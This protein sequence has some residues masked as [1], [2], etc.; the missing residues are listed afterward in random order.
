MAAFRSKTL[1]S[2]GHE[3]KLRLIYCLLNE[4][5]AT[6]NGRRNTDAVLTALQDVEKDGFHLTAAYF[7]LQMVSYHLAVMQKEQREQR[8]ASIAEVAVAEAGSPTVTSTSST[9][10]SPSIQAPASSSNVVPFD[11]FFRRP[12]CQPL[13][14]SQLI[15]KYYTRKVIDSPSARDQYTLPDLKKLPTIV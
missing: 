13:R 15:E 3:I 2:W 9:A 8:A 6:S 10:A 14:N 4:P 5:S 11:M 12:L 1:P 7:W